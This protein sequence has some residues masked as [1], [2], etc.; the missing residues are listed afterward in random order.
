MKEFMKALSLYLLLTRLSNEI[1]FASKQ[2][3]NCKKNRGIFI[4]ICGLGLIRYPFGVLIGDQA[5]SGSIP[6]RL[7]NYVFYRTTGN[8]AGVGELPMH[9]TKRSR[10]L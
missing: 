8:W 9:R 5:Y 10:F 1:R 3:I 2:C 4:K 6:V 7:Q